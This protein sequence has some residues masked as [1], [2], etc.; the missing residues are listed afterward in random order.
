MKKMLF[1]FL[2]V[3][4]VFIINAQP[5]D[6][7]AK[8]GDFYGVQVDPDGAIDIAKIPAMLANKE[9]FDTKVKAKIIDVC[10]KKG[11]WLKLQVDDGTTALVKMKDYGFFLPLAA[12][13]KTVILEGE[14]KMKN[15]SVEELK[16]YAEDAKKSKA[17]IDAIT[18]PEKEI[19]FTAKGIMILE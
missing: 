19:R 2:F 5:P 1:T 10:P 9:S 13:G 12:K 17:E 18:K 16:H 6:G 15:T 4:S 7:D 14:V 8:P 3:T 11:C